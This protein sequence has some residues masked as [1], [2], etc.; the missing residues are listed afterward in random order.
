MFS[1]Y[2]VAISAV[3]LTSASQV[4]LKVG[5]ARSVRTN[6]LLHAYLNPLSLA[7]YFF[8]FVATLLST[9][10]Y[11]YLP[12]KAAV[13]LLPSGFISVALLSFWLLKEKFSRLQ[14]AGSTFI[15]LGTVVFSL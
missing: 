11:Q 14:F 1:Y 10:A 6:N 13:V 15:I 5:A 9:Y 3:F 2:A 4:L 12:I 8:L 7:A